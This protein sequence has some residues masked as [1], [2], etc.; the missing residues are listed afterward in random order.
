MGTDTPAKPAA[1]RRYLYDLL[2]RVADKQRP[3]SKPI[4][5]AFNADDRAMQSRGQWSQPDI[6]R[7]A[8]DAYRAG[9]MFRRIAR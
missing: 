1:H 9:Y 6:R 3:E 2:R 8:K 5:E 4:V 7:L